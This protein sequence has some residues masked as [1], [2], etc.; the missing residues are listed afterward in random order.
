MKEKYGIGDVKIQLRKQ[1]P[2]GAG[3]GGGS[4][5]A[6]FVLKALNDLFNLSIET[7]ELENLAAQLGSDCPF[8]LM[9]VRN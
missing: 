9:Q 6:A 7:G 3:L 1:I 8:L 4:A 2:F 5:D